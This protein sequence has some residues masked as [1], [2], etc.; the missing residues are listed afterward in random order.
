MALKN[1]GF[2]MMNMSKL[3][4]P[5]ALT[6]LPKYSPS[7]FKKMDLSL[8]KTPESE[9]QLSDSVRTLLKELENT[10]SSIFSDARGPMLK[11]S[12]SKIIRQDGFEFSSPQQ[13]AFKG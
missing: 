3:L 7:F 5:V 12:S 9:K 8:M 13:P 4:A 11:N 6:K 10:S 2:P 1:L